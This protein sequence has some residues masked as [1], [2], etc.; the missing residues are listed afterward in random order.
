MR[1]LEA[2]TTIDEGLFWKNHPDYPSLCAGHCLWYSQI[3]QK[4]LMENFDIHSE[5]IPGEEDGDGDPACPHYFVEIPGQFLIDATLCQNDW[6]LPK[7]K[8]T[9]PHIIVEQI[10]WKNSFI[11]RNCRKSFINRKLLVHKEH[12][13]S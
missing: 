3:I 11:P 6:E 1:I 8:R 2:L 13:Y 5:V 7:E 10:T 9:I 4:Y 12:K